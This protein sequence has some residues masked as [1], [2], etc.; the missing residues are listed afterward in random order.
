MEGSEGVGTPCGEV[1]VGLL[2]MRCHRSLHSRAVRG[3]LVSLARAM[4][5]DT[6]VHAM[7]LCSW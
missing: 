1:S 5:L 2:L 7:G 3:I 4:N 6:S